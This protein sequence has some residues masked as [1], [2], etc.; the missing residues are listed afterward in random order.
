M[1]TT[2]N[3]G[4]VIINSVG[5]NVAFGLGCVIIGHLSSVFT[6][7][8][9][10]KIYFNQMINSDITVSVDYITLLLKLVY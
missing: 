9:F 4:L 5:G 7:P 6:I 3:S 10:I 2:M 8:F 1:P